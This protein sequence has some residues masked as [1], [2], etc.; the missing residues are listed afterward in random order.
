LAAKGHVDAQYTLGVMYD[1]GFGVWENDRKA[2]KLYS[3]AADQEYS[4]AQYNLGVMYLLG[5]GVR[6]NDKTAA[7]WFTLA[8][9]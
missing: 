3:L 1:E 8:P 4:N 6:Q 2:R 5:D 9:E 7:K